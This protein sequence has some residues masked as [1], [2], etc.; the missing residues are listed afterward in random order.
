MAHGWDRELHI[1][2]EEKEKGDGGGQK[3]EWRSTKKRGGKRAIK[4]K[5]MILSI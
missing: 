1:C 5:L 3:E 2:R 4:W